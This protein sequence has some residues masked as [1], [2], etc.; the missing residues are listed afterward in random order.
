MKIKLLYLVIALFLFSRCEPVEEPID[1]QTYEELSDFFNEKILDD[2]IAGMAAC[3]V[4]NNQVVWTENFGYANKENNLSVNNNTLFMLASV[5]NTVT[6]TAILQLYETGDLSLD[7]DIN[8]YLPFDVINP[9]SPN[10]PI[11]CRMLLSHVSGI[12]DNT[13]INLYTYGTDSPISL[14]NLCEEYFLPQ[15]QYY[16]DNLNFVNAESGT[17]YQFSNMGF[18]LLGY[19]VEVVSGKNFDTYCEENIFQPLNMTAT[20]W[21]LADI[22]L[23]NKAIPYDDR[24]NAYEHFTFADYPNGQ[25]MTTITDLSHFLIAFMNSGYYG[26]ESLLSPVTIELAKVIQYGE[27]QNEYGLGWYYSSATGEELYG[28]H[29]KRIGITTTMFYNQRTHIGAIILTNSEDADLLPYL[30]NMFTVAELQN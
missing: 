29:G 12:K 26:G 23:N 16:S 13:T 1:I 8:N 28:H 18:A 3:I 10:K 27:V 11:T 17:F 6:T 30:K 9:Y 2:K 22:V 25:L 14:Q 19:I 4:R 15:G 24:Q 20:S 7:A 21:K 5:S